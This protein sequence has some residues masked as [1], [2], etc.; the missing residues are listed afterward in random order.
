MPQSAPP[1][2]RS[3]ESHNLNGTSRA[4]RASTEVEQTSDTADEQASG[5]S[6]SSQ[7]G[8]ECWSSSLEAMHRRCRFAITNRLDSCH[9]LNSHL[10]RENAQ[11]VDGPMLTLTFPT[12]PGAHLSH[13]PGRS[14]FLPARAPPLD[15]RRRE[16]SLRV[17]GEKRC[18]P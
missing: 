4:F 17:M 12:W 11:P 14:P 3:L 5:Q 8:R 1:S 10:T 7:A 18:V 6:R 15:P 13:L 2:V 9:P 16:S